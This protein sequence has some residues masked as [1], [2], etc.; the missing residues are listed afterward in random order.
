LLAWKTYI[1][2]SFTWLFLGSKALFLFFILY[3]LYRYGHI[4]LGQKKDK[5][6]FSSL[7]TFIMI[8]AAGVGP[9]FFVYSVAESMYHRA[10]HFFAKSG[11]RSQD[12][13]DMFAINMTL[14]DWGLT[15]WLTFTV[16]A[17]AAALATHRFGLPLTFRS[18]FYPIFGAYTWG[19]MGDVIDGMAIVLMILGVC[20]MLCTSTLQIVS[21]LVH[22]GWIDPNSTDEELM[23]VQKTT[24]WIVTF[25]SIASVISG[26]RGG[27]RYM[28]FLAVTTAVFLGLMVFAMEDTKFILNLQVQTLGYHL[29][30]SI[31]QLNFWTDAFGQLEEGAGRAIDG[32][33]AEQWWITSWTVFYQAWT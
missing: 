3:T 5:P 17:V 32:N 22:L 13:I 4:H 31:F 23:M 10:D 11:Y 2:S 18:C 26:L 12:E 8:F 15:T 30:T 14:C 7:T 27:I 28:S 9:V 25:I 6:E 19:W 29:Q 1:A 21:G 33:A 24:V 16:V 20:S